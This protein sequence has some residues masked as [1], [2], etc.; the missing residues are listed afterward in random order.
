MGNYLGEIAALSTAFCW[1]ITATAFETTGKKIGSMNLNLLRLLLGMVFLSVFTFITRGYL[2]PVDASASEWLWLLMSGFVGIVIG[3]LLLF[4]AFVQIGSRISMLIY[5]SVP[6]LSGILAFVFLGESM[7]AIQVLG[8][9]VTLAGIASV[10]LVGGKDNKRVSF[11]HPIKGILLAFGGAL[12]QA[13]GYII[14][15]FGMASYDPFASTQIRLLAGM[16]G[17]AIIFFIRNNWKS[18]F[19]SLKRTDALKSATIGSFFG[20]FLGISL[21]LYAVQKINPGVA[22]TLTS[23]TPVLL[24]PFAFFIKKEKIAIREVIGTLITLVGVGI[25]FI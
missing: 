20:P 7:K 25:M 17:F 4:E 22:S 3:D 1:A 11:S 15:K 10:I 2:F 13:A 14:G 12:G 24:I 9:I 16:L 19:Q 21:S 5:A 6:P 8:M 23:I 18:F